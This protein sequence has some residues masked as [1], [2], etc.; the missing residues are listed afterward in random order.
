MNR[1]ATFTTTMSRVFWVA[2]GACL[3]VC[4]APLAAAEAAARPHAQNATVLSF[5]GVDYV[6]RWSKN[7]QN[8]FTPRN[9]ADLAHWRNMITVIVYDG[10]RNGDQLAGTANSVLTMYQGNGQ[11]VRTDSKP[12]T[13]QHPAEHLIVALLG[14]PGF[15]EAVFARFVLIDDVGIATVYSHRVYGEDAANPMDEWLEANGPSIE[16]TLMAWDRIPLPDV[17]RRLPQSK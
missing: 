12:R 13:P 6:H 17:L 7:N 10:V 8:E 15:L 16:K 5:G 11:I 3:H 4:T 9:E 1:S 2:V 14:S